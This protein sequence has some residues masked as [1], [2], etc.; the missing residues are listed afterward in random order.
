MRLLSRAEVL[1]LDIFDTTL[2]RYCARPEDVVLELA[3]RAVAQLGDSLQSFAEVRGEAEH[4]ARRLAWERRQAEDTTLDEIYEQVGVL[5]ADWEPWLNQLQRNELDL[6][7]SLLYPL[8][9]A[10]AMISSARKLGKRVIFVSDMYLPKDFCEDVLRSNGFDDFDAFFLSSAD[11]L[12][13][14][15]GNLFKHVIRTLKCA[16]A[17]ILHVGDNP[18]PMEFRR[19][20]LAFGHGACPKR[21]IV[22]LLFHTIRYRLYRMYRPAS[23]T[24][25]SRSW[26][27]CLP[28]S[29]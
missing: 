5:R 14:Q 9:V 23:A 12:L 15:T 19:A 20:R 2:A 7:R 28:A 16:P 27:A 4:R 17:A 11:G 21:L 1:S 3:R 22:C 25:V 10:Q 26:S 29:V 18:Q 8:P 13:K 24:G 6:E